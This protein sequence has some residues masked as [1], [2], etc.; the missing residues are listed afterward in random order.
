MQKNLSRVKILLIF[1]VNFMFITACGSPQ[2]PDTTPPVP[3]I[4]SSEDYQVQRENCTW[5][6]PCWPEIVDTIPGSFSEAPMLAEKVKSGELPSVEERLPSDPLVIQPT[7]MIGIYGG[8]WRRAFTGPGDRQNIERIVNDYNIYWDASSTELRPRVVKQWE[9][10]D[11]ASEWVFYLREGM[12][13]SDGMLFTADDYMFW[14]EHILKNE[15]LTVAVPWYLQ[16]GGELAIFEKVD[17]YTVKI[18]FS[19]PFPSWPEIMATDTVAGHFHQGRNGG[20]GGLFAPKHYLEQFHPDFIGEENANQKAQAAGFESWSLYFLTQNDPQM[21][22]N[23]PVVTPWKPITTI[24]SNEYLLER[25]PY[26]FAVDTQ[27]N[28]LPYFDYIS[29]ELVEDLEVLNLR[30]IAGNYT[31]QGRHIDFAKLPVIREN[32]QSGDYFVDFWTNRTRHQIVISFNQDWDAIPEIAQFTHSRDFRQALSLTI[33]R[34]EI[35]EIFFLGVGK[36]SSFCPANTP[37]FFNSA[38]WDDEFGRFDPD[39]AN[40]ILDSL[41]LEQRD[42][43]GYR[44]LPNGERLTLRIDAVSGAFLDYPGI[45]ER[46]AQTWGKHIGIHLTVNPVERSL[47][48]ERMQANQSMMNMFALGSWDASVSPMLLLNE[49]WAP[50]ATTWGNTPNPDPADYDGPE[51]IEEMVLK[52]WEAIQEPD[53][54]RRLQLYV[55]GTEVLCDNHPR[56][57]MVVDLPSHTTLIRNNVRNVPKPLERTRYAQTPGHGYPEQFFVLPE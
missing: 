53:P 47:Y 31:I 30:A 29:L 22:P 3:E 2:L 34:G 39:E 52:H 7:E 5:D 45:S 51:W 16:W 33:E 18:K 26:F 35:N 44:L 55:E 11:D 56:I 38:R 49:D 37:P 43:E 48:V 41:G 8:T 12:R 50:I 27:G 6:T 54:E 19:Q 23:V 24:A 32:A 10:N 42:S 21:N 20:G 36:E 17:D 57:G 14:Y 40:E 13:W 28:Q 46:I 1:V 4:Q 9:S 15:R 25:N